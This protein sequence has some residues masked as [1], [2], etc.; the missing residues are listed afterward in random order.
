[1]ETDRALKRIES[2]AS[3]NLLVHVGAYEQDRDGTATHV[4][5]H[6]RARPGE[7][8]GGNSSGGKD[9]P[10]MGSPVGRELKFRGCDGPPYG[11]GYYGARRTKPDGTVYEHK[12]VDVVAEP[13]ETVQSPVAGTVL[14]PF[15]PYR[16]DPEKQDKLSAV[17]IKIDGGHVVEILYVDS[18]SAGLKEGDKVEIGIPIGR[19]QDLSTVYPPVGK[20]RMTNH[21]DIRIKDKNGVYKD[22]TPLIRGQR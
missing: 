11:C 3:R 15:D 19:A 2:R 6:T 5:E 1:D 9:L 8:A 18:K 13:G 16:S 22:P 10:P 12:G 17:R 14:E 20:T 7:G 21:V 4:S